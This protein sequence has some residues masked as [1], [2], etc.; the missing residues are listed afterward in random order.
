MANVLLQINNLLLKF[1]KKKQTI[2]CDTCKSWHKHLSKISTSIIQDLIELVYLI[3]EWTK[4]CC[5]KFSD[6]TKTKEIH[7]EQHMK[8]LWSDFIHIVLFLP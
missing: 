5:I 1:Y 2:G 7:K 8:S 6:D 3:S 4:Q